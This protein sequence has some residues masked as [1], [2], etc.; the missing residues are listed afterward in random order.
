M[1]ETLLYTNKNWHDSCLHLTWS[2]VR[3]LTPDWRAARPTTTGASTVRSLHIAPEKEFHTAPVAAEGEAGRA[4]DEADEDGTAEEVL[5][6]I[7]AN[8]EDTA[9]EFINDELY[10]GAS[11]DDDEDLNDLEVEEDEE[12][13]EEAESS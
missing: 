13:G 1:L 8:E 11:S 9:L 3:K 5:E 4:E 6:L 12:M 2:Q 7:D 10:D